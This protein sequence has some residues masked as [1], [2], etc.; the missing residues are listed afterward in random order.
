MHLQIQDKRWS[1][2]PLS[3]RELL[4][5]CDSYVSEIQFWED[6][7]A[8]VATEAMNPVYMANNF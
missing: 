2:Q 5:E 7:T 8:D 6:F 1:L 3:T 4:T